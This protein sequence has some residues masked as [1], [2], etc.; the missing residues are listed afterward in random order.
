M[1]THNSESEMSYFGSVYEV[2]ELFDLFHWPAFKNKRD[3]TPEFR[4]ES[5]SIESWRGPSDW[6]LLYDEVTFWR[7]IWKGLST[8]LVNST[9]MIWLH[10]EGLQAST[11]GLFTHSPPFQEERNFLLSLQLNK[12]AIKGTTFVVFPSIQLER[13]HYASLMTAQ[14]PQGGQT[15]CIKI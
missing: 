15:S 8:R 6:H 10:S 13:R 4:F 12:Q 11:R 14:R 9:S 3:K 1:P 7:N 5:G 2:F